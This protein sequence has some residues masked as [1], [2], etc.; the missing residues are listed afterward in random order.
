[1]TTGAI[2]RKVPGTGWF[3][4]D[5]RLYLMLLLPLAFYLIF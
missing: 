2:R 5:W 4:R 1:M 3:S